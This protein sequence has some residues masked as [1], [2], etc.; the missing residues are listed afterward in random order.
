MEL[1]TYSDTIV[2]FFLLL[3]NARPALLPEAEA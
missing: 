2:Y 1:Q 3:P